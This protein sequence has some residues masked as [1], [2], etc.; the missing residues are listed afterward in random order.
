MKKYILSNV[1][2]RIGDTNERCI[3][4]PNGY[5]TMNGKRVTSYKRAD[6]DIEYNDEGIPVDRQYS[7]DR[8]HRFWVETEDEIYDWSR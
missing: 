3:M 7:M 4:Y 5:W 2:G 6:K 1:A 8:H